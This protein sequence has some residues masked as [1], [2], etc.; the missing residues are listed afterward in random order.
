M[1]AI[2][3]K[4]CRFVFFHRAKPPL[5][6]GMARV[7]S[8]VLRGAGLAGVWLLSIL[9][10]SPLSSVSQARAETPG[11]R[12]LVVV[13][14]SGSMQ[15]RKDAALN[16]VDSLLVSE[17]NK[18]LRPGDTIGVWTFNSQ[19]HTGKLPLKRW[20][21]ETAKGIR[22]DISRFLGQ[23][24]FDGRTDLAPLTGA[25]SQLSSNSPLLTVIIV[26][27]GEGSVSGTPFDESI[28]E[29][30]SAWKAEQLKSRMPMVTILR[31]SEGKFSDHRVSP[32]QY[33]V[34][35][36][37]LRRPRTSDVVETKPAEIAR[38]QPP[39]RKVEPLIIS[40][41]KK[42]PEPA[43]Q[44]N[45]NLLQNSA[46]PQ[47]FAATQPI[48]TNGE[49][50]IAQSPAPAGVNKIP[51]VPGSRI[52]TG[53]VNPSDESQ[54]ERGQTEQADAIV[55]KAKASYRIWMLAA[56]TGL[57]AGV[58]LGCFLVIRARR[59]ITTASLISLSLDPNR[60]E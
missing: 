49:A 51:A 21:P 19:L 46:A 23:Q 8:S 60:R 59:R 20:S 58:V 31:A 36:P 38:P 26:S 33:A 52:E 22:D 32:G 18:Q 41:R 53:A 16:T 15:R 13:E 2:Q 35:I 47:L 43:L 44:A 28:N 4:L 12:W 30:W 55:P 54:T 9:L 25:L 34:E 48:A 17:M 5:Q 14:T 56:G 29:V 42:E 24:S 3:F 39:P 1:P 10:I 11:K 50:P 7:V 6:S 45:T 27:S 37:P 57:L 40:G